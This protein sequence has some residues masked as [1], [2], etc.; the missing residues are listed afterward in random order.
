[1]KAKIK[2]LTAKKLLQEQSF[3]KQPIKKPHIK[4]LK[5]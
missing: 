3:Y 4:N 1:M 2:Q 5:N